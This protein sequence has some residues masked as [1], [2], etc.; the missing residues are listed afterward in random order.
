MSR[1]GSPF[2]AAVL[3]AAFPTPP[4][5]GS[6]LPRAFEGAA[7]CFVVPSEYRR[8]GVAQG[9]LDGAVAYAKE[10]GATLLEAYPVDKPCRSNDDGKTVSTLRRGERECRG[11]A[12]IGI[13]VL[14]RPRRGTGSRRSGKVVEPGHGP[15]R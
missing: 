13:H 1:S 9:L 12:A 6:C 15:G 4:G 7:I 3:K 14:P 10:Q 2:R 8:Q 5:H 11:A